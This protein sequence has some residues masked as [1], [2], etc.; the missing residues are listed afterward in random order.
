MR[1]LGVGL[2]YWPQLEPLLCTS[3]TLSV[4][5]LEL[6]SFWKL[7]ERDSG[8]LYCANTSLLDH[9]ASRPEAKLIHGVNHPLG[10]TVADPVD[11]WPLFQDAVRRLAPIWISEHLSFNRVRGPNGVE[12]VGYLLPPRQSPAAVRV[13]AENISA[14]RNKLG[15]PVAF[16]TGV[17]YLRSRDDEMPDG[18]FSPPSL[19][20]RTAAFCLIC[21]IYGA[22][23]AMVGRPWRMRCPRSRS[24]GSGNF[25]LQGA[26]RNS[27]SGWTLTAMPFHR[28]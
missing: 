19:E 7:T 12:H 27:G 9:I 14:L 21:T 1:N 17:S 18:E 4:I 26:S 3:S 28:R 11:P 20:L 5:E 15:C 25:I 23:S 2:V 10:G 24:I 22:T 16:E 8:R 13:A 6:Q